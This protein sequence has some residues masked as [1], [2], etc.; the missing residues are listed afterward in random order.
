MTLDSIRNSCDVLEISGYF[1]Y[2][3]VLL[4]ISSVQYESPHVWGYHLN[5]C[6]VIRP[7]TQVFSNQLTQQ[8]VLQ[9]LQQ[10]TLYFV[11]GIHGIWHILYDIYYML[12]LIII[13]AVVNSGKLYVHPFLPKP[14]QSLQQS[15]FLIKEIK[16][17]F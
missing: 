15:F 9:Y 6:I 17:A 7:K 10:H 8:L 16:N 3:W 13:L 14:T 2:F 1:G 5:F 11:F 12:A 4:E